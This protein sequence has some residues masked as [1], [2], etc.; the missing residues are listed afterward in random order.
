LLSRLITFGIGQLRLYQPV[1]KHSQTQKT[2][3][4][5][6]NTLQEPRADM[7]PY[8]IKRYHD[9]SSYDRLNMVRMGLQNVNK[10]VAAESRKTYQGRSNFRLEDDIASPDRSLFELIRHKPHSKSGLDLESLTRVLFMAYGVTAVRRRL[11]KNF[12]YRSPPSAGALYPCEIYVALNGLDGL[13]DGL[14][15]YSSQDHALTLLRPGSFVAPGAVAFFVSAV[16]S[17]SARKYRERAF[18]YCLI[19][20]GHLSENLALAQISEG[21]DPGLSMDFDDKEVNLFLGIDPEQEGCLLVGNS[22]LLNDLPPAADLEFAQD[23]QARSQEGGNQVIKEILLAS[24]K[25]TGPTKSAGSDPGRVGLL[26]GPKQPWPEASN[27]HESLSFFKTVIER[28]SRRNFIPQEVPSACFGRLIELLAEEPESA[29]QIGF[30]AER[31]EG[32][33]AGFYLLNRA[34]SYFSPIT[35]GALLADMASIC[36]DHQAWLGRAALH[37]IFLA[38]LNLLDET[39]GPRGYRRAMIEAGRFGQRLYLGATALGFGCCGVG[40]FYDS[41]AAEFLGLN[42]ESRLLYLVAVGPIKSGK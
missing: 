9:L 33:K 26:P 39:E 11:G 15:H 5:N 4:N 3:K 20:A 1:N 6:F 37:F 32:L 25:L 36:L 13:H 34:E 38:N 10:P 35:E 42:P 41:E 29:V 22:G 23:S 14:Y 30:L 18:R 19:D 21:L 2:E 8:S 31:I 27:C 7:P 12:M 28:R 17:R 16:F 40:S 24:S